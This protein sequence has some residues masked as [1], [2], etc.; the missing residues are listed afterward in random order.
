MFGNHSKLAGLFVA[1]FLVLFTGCTEGAP[2][3]PEQIEAPAGQ[4]ATPAEIE[5]QVA[6]LVDISERLIPALE[7][8]AL[9]K[10]LAPKVSEVAKALGAHDGARVKTA[11]AAALEVLTAYEAQNGTETADAADLGGI[12]L[13]LWYTAAS[14]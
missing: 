14:V 8:Q 3:A 10:A 7:D 12:Y 6:Q 5:A 2:T 11:V 13:N 9:A 1:F 4:V